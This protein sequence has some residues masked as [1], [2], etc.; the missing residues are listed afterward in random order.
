MRNYIPPTDRCSG[1]TFN[2]NL[3]GEETDS[4]C[5]SIFANEVV[6]LTV[7]IA[8]PSVMVIEKDVSATFSDMLG[9]VGKLVVAV[10]IED[11]DVY[12]HK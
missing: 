12:F 9:I 4:V 6:K 8:D 10:I 7:Q 5:Q 2:Y 3:P 11:A 1:Q